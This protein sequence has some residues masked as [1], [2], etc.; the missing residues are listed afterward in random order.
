MGKCIFLSTA[1]FLGG[2]GESEFPIVTEKQLCTVSCREIIILRIFISKFRFLADWEH[3]AKFKKEQKATNDKM[4]YWV[5]DALESD[6]QSLND[7]NVAQIPKY[8]GRM[9]RST[10]SGKF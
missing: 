4:R 2:G 8:L 9:F 6:D 1:R 10:T 7:A 5:R 3:C